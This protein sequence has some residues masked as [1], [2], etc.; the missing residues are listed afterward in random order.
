MGEGGAD[1]WGCFGHQNSIDRNAKAYGLNYEPGNLHFGEE[2]S[3]EDRAEPSGNRENGQ[4]ASAKNARSLRRQL[5]E[6]RDEE[7]RSIA[8]ILHDSTLQLLTAAGLGAD[9]VRA[10]LGKDDQ[11]GVVL[12]EVRKNISDA[13]KQISNLTYMIYPQRPGQ[14]GL[15][16]ALTEVC[17]GLSRRTG[18]AIDLEPSDTWE[19]LPPEIATVV[20]RVVQEAINNVY[21]HADATTVRITLSPS[22]DLLRLSIADDGK[23]SDVERP[24]G[25]TGIGLQSCRDRAEAI[26]GTLDLITA[27]TGSTLVVN[28]PREA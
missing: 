13:Q 10:A 1:G 18:L 26:G 6:V 2:L 4:A 19:R 12:A 5:V 11:L 27:P 24:R 17:A 23:G 25:T 21:K 3:H 20:I 14:L 7:R 9:R 8:L 22:D 16:D 28:L 15:R